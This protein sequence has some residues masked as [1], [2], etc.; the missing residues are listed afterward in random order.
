MVCTAT[1]RI[2]SLNKNWK[3]L[4]YAFSGFGPN[5]LMVL[6]GSY[7]SDALNPAAL[8]NGETFQA[9]V[10]GMYFIMPALFPILYAIGKVFDGLI[11]IPFAHITDNLSTKWGRRRPAI[12]VCAIPMV[13]SFA[14]SWIMPEQVNNSLVNTIWVTIWNLIFFATYTMCMITFY[15]S[16]STVCTDEPQRL[17]VAG[18]KS[19]FD[20]ISYCLVYALVPVILKGAQIQI[21]TFVFLCL[22]LMLTIV[23]PLFLIKEGEKYGYPE[24]AGRAAEKISML[25]SIR[26][27]FANRIFRRWLYVNCFTFFGLQM[28]LAGM[29]GMIIGG[30][31]LDGL[32]MAILNTFAFG[33]VPIMLYLFNKL[34]AKRG[35][36]FAYQSCLVVFAVAIMC[37][38]LGS[39]FLLGEGNVPLK[40]IIGIAGS[41]LGS[42]SIGVFFMLPYLA[43]TQISSVEERLTGKNHS[44]MYFAGNAVV[45]SI[46]GAISGSLVYEYIKNIFLEKESFRLVWAS[47]SEEAYRKLHDISDAAAVLP[48]G[49]TDGIYNFGNLLVPFIVAVACILGAIVACKMPRDFTSDVLA[50]EFKSMDPSLDISRLENEKEPVDKSEILFVQIGLWVLSGSVFGFIWS[51]ILLRAIKREFNRSFK[52]LI[53]Y[54]ASTLVPFV[55]IWALLR[56][57]AE[58]LKA[59]DEKG[60]KITISKVALIASAVILPLLPLNFIGLAILQHKYN[61]LVK[62][63]AAVPAVA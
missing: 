50:Q 49:A 38:F 46:V 42:W 53:P 39:R 23:I 32:Q 35:V 45:T 43:P 4:L 26:L 13:L 12:A 6:M 20:T 19:F 29:N 30:M 3:E 17:R 60:M 9:I 5:L 47:G 44:A 37:F 54:L 48:D 51:G 27:T 7:Y 63:D 10:P 25:E 58:L 61:K 18:Y 34:K 14:L 55:S 22:P 62:E 57:R 33:P 52:I 24:N 28:F 59:A 56:M 16:L 41:L 11:D 15:G 21:D 40:M 1:S 8:E 2:R 31:G 36:R